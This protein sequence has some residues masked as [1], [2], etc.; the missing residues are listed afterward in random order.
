MKSTDSP[1]RKLIIVYYKQLLRA[2]CNQHLTIFKLPV[3]L[4]LRIKLL[5]SNTALAD[6]IKQLLNALP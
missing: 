2:S 6:V 4:A 1:T 5:N 3:F